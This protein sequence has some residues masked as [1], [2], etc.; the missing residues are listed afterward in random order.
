VLKHLIAKRVMAICFLTLVFAVS[1]TASFAGEP[2]YPSYSFQANKVAIL[3]FADYSHQASFNTALKW[4]GNRRIVEYLKNE[5]LARGIEVVDQDKVVEVLLNRGAIKEMKDV[6]KFGTP[7]YELFHSPHW[8]LFTK[9]LFK[10]IVKN[11]EKTT[12]ISRQEIREIGS[13]LGVD[14]IVRGT[15]LHYELQPRQVENTFEDLIPF[16]LIHGKSDKPVVGYAIGP[17]YEKDIYDRFEIT[18]AH[19]YSAM[20]PL[21]DKSSRIIVIIFVQDAKTGD[22][23]T[24]GIAELPYPES[25]FN[26]DLSK[27]LSLACKRLFRLNNYGYLYIKQ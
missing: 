12:P 14:T 25:E 23:I 2:K 7:E 11:Q 20:F 6:D 26:A 24:N 5:L 21:N 4:G 22:I 1:S 27:T 3:P 15:I 18:A 13:I 10:K 8:E 16:S 9:E 17:E 19:D